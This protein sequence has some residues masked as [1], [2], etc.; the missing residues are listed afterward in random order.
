MLAIKKLAVLALATIALTCS[1][2]TLASQVDAAPRRLR[3]EPVRL[4][5]SY[6][7]AAVNTA[8][9]SD[10]VA[11]DYGEDE[12]RASADEQGEGDSTVNEVRSIPD[13]SP[14]IESRGQLTD[15][16][17]DAALDKAAE[18]AKK[19]K[20]KVKEKVK[21]KAKQVKDKVKEKVK[22]KAKEV[23]DRVKDRVKQK[24]KDKINGV[25]SAGGSTQPAAGTDT[26]PPADTDTSGSVSD[27]TDAETE[28]ASG[29]DET[30]RR[31]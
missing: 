1:P 23:T 16:L 3:S 22:A 14:E 19:V 21:T 31:L 18:T 10:A 11:A 13:G 12:V 20:D 17:V 9:E 30:V 27:T 29:A 2:V 24:I 25:P 26:S 7:F 4:L 28:A 5:T 15:M 6:D 8:E